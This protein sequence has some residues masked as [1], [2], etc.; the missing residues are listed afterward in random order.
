MISSKENFC[1]YKLSG[2]EDP[3]GLPSTV[4][5]PTGDEVIILLLL[6]RGINHELHEFHGLKRKKFVK[7]V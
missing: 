1:C 5:G 3:T 2:G 7:S 6:L 4:L